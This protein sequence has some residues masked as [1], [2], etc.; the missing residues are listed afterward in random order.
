VGKGMSEKRHRVAVSVIDHGSLREEEFSGTR[1]DPDKVI[2]VAVV[3]RSRCPDKARLAAIHKISAELPRDRENLSVSGFEEKYG[4]VPGDLEKI[5]EFAEASRL[6]FVRGNKARCDAV[7]RGTLAHFSY[8]FGVHFLTYQ[9]ADY[10]EYRSYDGPVYVP[11]QLADVVVGVL[12]FDARPLPHV[13]SVTSAMAGARSSPQDV[14][15]FYH[16][17]EG[18]TG[19][20]QNIG[21]IELGGGFH[22]ADLEAFLANNS[23]KSSHITVIEMDGAK[24]R[25]ASMEALQDAFQKQGLS[26]GKNPRLRWGHWL[27]GHM[28]PVKDSERNIAWT[29][30]ATMDVELIAGFA[31]Q[32]HLFVYFAPNTALGKYDSFQ[33]AIFNPKADISVISCSWGTQE[34]NLPARYLQ[35]VDRMYQFAVLRGITICHSSGDDGASIGADGRPHVH[36][37]ASSPYVLACGGTHVYPGKSEEKHWKEKVGEHVFES[38]HG[39]SSHFAEPH[40]QAA[41]RSDGRA[42]VCEQGRHVPD[43]VGKA[44]LAT[45]YDCV[46]GQTRAPGGGTSAAAPMWASL[47]ALV[48]EQL[49]VRA[50][51]ITPLLY[52]P[53]FKG[54]TRK[55]GEENEPGGSTPGWHPRHG[56][57]SPDGAS[58]LAALKAR[59]D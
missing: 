57:G 38:G 6:E 35:V 16:F 24:N 41:H 13:P 7:L 55:I 2:D 30:E 50:G 20:G 3:L 47:I 23:L 51:Y 12:G 27:R 48:N 49:G 18:A 31:N 56:L 8:A 19:R 5:R 52:H 54:A 53:R 17:P 1:P 37:P 40:W 58:L 22:R 43:V 45:G 15:R 29:T 32:A 9:H 46:V 25:P 21:L 33:D 4:A 44:D 14:A 26:A 39:V 36:F 28:D 11:E 42:G 59:G 34:D 10:G